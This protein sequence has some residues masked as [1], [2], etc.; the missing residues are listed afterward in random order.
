MFRVLCLNLNQQG[1]GFGKEGYAVKN[2]LLLI[3]LYIL[4]AFGLAQLGF[5]LNPGLGAGGCF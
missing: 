1:S 2:K 5:G 3:D 4:E